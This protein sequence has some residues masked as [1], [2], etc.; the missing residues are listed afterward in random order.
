MS[1]PPSDTYR[2]MVDPGWR[3]REAA[4]AKALREAIPKRPTNPGEISDPTPRR[5]PL[6]HY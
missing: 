2:D 5:H 4:A 1:L 6:A 3:E